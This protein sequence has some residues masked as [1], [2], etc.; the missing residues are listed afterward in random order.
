MGNWFWIHDY[1]ADIGISTSPSNETT[2]KVS[3]INDNQKNIFYVNDTK[4]HELDASNFTPDWFGINTFESNG[5]A[6]SVFADHSILE[7]IKDDILG[8]QLPVDAP[9]SSQLVSMP[10]ER[11]LRIRFYTLE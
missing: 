7:L 8:V 4:V 11:F 1:V 3:V 5:Q 2:F 9:S 6:Y 10:L